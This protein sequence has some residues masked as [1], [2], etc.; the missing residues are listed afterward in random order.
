MNLAH[1]K[2][3]IVPKMQ[4]I[5][6]RAI[7]PFFPMPR[8]SR[9]NLGSVGLPDCESFDFEEALPLFDDADDDEGGDEGFPF[10][11]DSALNL[12]KDRE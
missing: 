7:L 9:S 4:N 10:S 8:E 3:S 5:T 12:E 11:E 2:V 6:I 1:V